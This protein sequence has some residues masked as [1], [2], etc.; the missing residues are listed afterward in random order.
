[1]PDEGYICLH[2]Q[3]VIASPSVHGSGGRPSWSG[4]HGKCHSLVFVPLQFQ[5]QIPC[6]PRVRHHSDQ[7]TEGNEALDCWLSWARRS[8]PP[9]FIELAKKITRHRQAIDANL[10]HGLSQGLIESTNT[11]I[12]LLTRLAFGFDGPQPLFA[13]ALLALGSHPPQLPG[14]N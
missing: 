7:N 14:R 2:A 13:L 10:E 11:K 1:M 9:A 3:G 12:R 4:S 6:Q 5:C 8:Q